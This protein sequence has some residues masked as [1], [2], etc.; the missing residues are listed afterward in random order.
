VFEI[1]DLFQQGL[2]PEQEGV[3]MNNKSQRDSKRK[4][5]GSSATPLILRK[6]SPTESGAF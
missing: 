6:S 2:V 3:E 4:R 5:V 1:F